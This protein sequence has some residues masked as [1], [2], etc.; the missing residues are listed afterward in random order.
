MGLIGGRQAVSS[1]LHFR[2]NFTISVEGHPAFRLRV[3]DGFGR[4]I[5]LAAPIFRSIFGA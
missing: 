5:S 2:D 1:F 3:D 4:A